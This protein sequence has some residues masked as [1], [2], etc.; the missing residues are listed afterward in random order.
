MANVY[1]CM[2]KINNVKGRS[3]HIRDPKRQEYIVLLK[4]DLKQGW[5][6]VSQFEKDKSNKKK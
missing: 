1:S 5:D 2:T 3:N 4:Q 6:V